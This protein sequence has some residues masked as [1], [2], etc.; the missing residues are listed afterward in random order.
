MGGK[1]IIPILNKNSERI[2]KAEKNY[3]LSLLP[4]NFLPIREIASKEDFGDIDLLISNPNFYNLFE[5][6]M[7]K[8]NIKINGKIKNSEITSYAINDKHQIDLILLENTKLAWEYYSDNDK[9]IIIGNIFHQLGFSYGHKGL[10]LKLE[11]TKF[12]LSTNTF[13]ILNFLKYPIDGIE[14]VINPNLFFSTF[15]EMFEFAISTP[16]F[17]SAYY[18]D[19][20]LNNENRTR[21]NKRNTWNKFRDFLQTKTFKNEFIPNKEIMKLKALKFFNKEAEY[22]DLLYSEEINKIKKKLFDGNKISS[23]TN[24]KNKDLGDFIIK[25]K[26]YIELELNKINQEDLIKYNILLNSIDSHILKFME[27]TK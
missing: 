17:N 20:F 22:L 7:S 27:N 19:A 26:N 21:N 24:L 5:T 10:Y 12:L 9:G 8:N 25:F 4:S 23:I 11:N 1:A 13:D 16:Y 14:K 15:E 2:T 6:V 18:G 3:Y